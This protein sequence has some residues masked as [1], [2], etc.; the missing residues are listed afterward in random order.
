M[1]L[2]GLNFRG[3]FLWC[4]SVLFQIARLFL[5]FYQNHMAFWPQTSS[6]SFV[7]EFTFHSAFKFVFLKQ[8]IEYQITIKY[9]K[10]YKIIIDIPI[11]FSGPLAK[12]IVTTV[13]D[14]LILN[15][16]RL[17]RRTRSVH[18][19]EQEHQIV[20]VPEFDLVIGTRLFELY[21]SL[22]VRI[23]LSIST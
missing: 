22:Q 2:I 5:D 3:F 20:V 7:R 16:R 14:R 9:S 15:Q 10:H 1:Y 12:S 8:L 13:C 11:I 17:K 6:F 21:L 23:I 19:T 18:S 4:L